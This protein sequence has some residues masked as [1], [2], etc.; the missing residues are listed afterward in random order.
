M[1]LVNTKKML[2]EAYRGRYAV[3]AFNFSSMETMQGI[4][5]ACSK[6]RSPVILQVSKSA[7]KYSGYTYLLKLVEAATINCPYIPIALHLDHGDSF[8]ICKN[9]IDQGFTS[10][11]IDGSDLG[12]KENI[13]LTKSVVKYAHSKEVTVEGELGRIFGIEDGVKVKKEDSFYTNP[14]EIEDFVK[15]TGV[16][17]LAIAIGTSHGVCKFANKQKPKLR[18]DILEEIGRILPEFPIVLHGSSSV[19]QEF[20]RIIN[21]YGG[22]IPNAVGVPEYILRKATSMSVCKINIDSDIRLAVTA[23]IRRYLAHDHPADFDPRG[24]MSVARESIL[25]LVTHKIKAV[26]RSEN[27]I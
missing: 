9:C 18:F 16:D 13:A 26:L 10:V 15:K 24:Y 2:K 5:E 25:N 17:S 12:Y 22:K 14:E 21:K 11:M 7:I 8:E 3:G 6:L 19:N 23:S 20:V 27:K 1:P 4:I